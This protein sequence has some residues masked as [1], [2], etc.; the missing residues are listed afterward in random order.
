MIRTI[1]NNTRNELNDDNSLTSAIPHILFT[2]A[3]VITFVRIGCCYYCYAS[4]D[5]LANP[6]IGGEWT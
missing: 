4:E 3:I 2:V 6:L 5:T 1:H